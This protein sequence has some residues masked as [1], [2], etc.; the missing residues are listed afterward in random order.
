MELG[1]LRW[2]TQM[3]LSTLKTDT[4]GHQDELG[5]HQDSPLNRPYGLVFKVHNLNF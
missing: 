1:S 2:R 4:R 5:I 3:K